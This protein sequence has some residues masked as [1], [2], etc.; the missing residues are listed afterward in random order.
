M[1]PVS[2]GQGHCLR[3]LVTRVRE[4][5]P[6]HWLL[7]SVYTP[8]YTQSHKMFSFFSET[9]SFYIGLAS[10][11]ESSLEPTAIYLPLLPK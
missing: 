11:D 1:G 9:G 7:T 8:T 5:I 10:L 6:S 4:V 3:S 2:S